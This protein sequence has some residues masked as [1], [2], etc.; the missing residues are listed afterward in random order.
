MNDEFRESYLTSMLRSMVNKNSTGIKILESVVISIK[1][2]FN[3]I[4]YVVL[5][6]VFP[7]SDQEGFLQLVRK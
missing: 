5:V 3:L 6:R 1:S 7:G 4:C 2:T